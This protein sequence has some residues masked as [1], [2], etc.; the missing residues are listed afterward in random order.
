[1]FTS[2]SHSGLK[3][4][5][6][7]TWRNHPQNYSKTHEHRCLAVLQ[8]TVHCKLPAQAGEK[9]GCDV[10]DDLWPRS[11]SAAGVCLVFEV[12]IVSAVSVCERKKSHGLTDWCVCVRCRLSI[13]L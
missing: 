3:V 10:G 6:S 1:M 11:Y 9:I 7:L 5:V 8:A 12:D 13:C 2:P 4:F